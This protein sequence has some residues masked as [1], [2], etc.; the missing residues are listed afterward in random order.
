[1]A[2]TRLSSPWVL[3]LAQV[4]LTA[5]ILG[6]YA[7]TT[8]PKTDE[9]KKQFTKSIVLGGVVAAALLMF[10]NSQTPAILDPTIVPFDHFQTS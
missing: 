9:A 3:L 5:A 8:H 7:A 4:V 1:M 6:A 10:K 2:S